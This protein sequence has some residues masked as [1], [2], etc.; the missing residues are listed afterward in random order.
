MFGIGYILLGTAYVL[1]YKTLGSLSLVIGIFGML[2]GFG[3]VSILMSIPALFTLTVFEILM[4]V[5]IFKVM[6]ATTVAIDKNNKE[7]AGVTV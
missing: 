2:T 3:F 6:N 4:L 1:R 5:L 7:F